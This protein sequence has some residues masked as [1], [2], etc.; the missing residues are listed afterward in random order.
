MVA[1]VYHI[2]GYA[3]LYHHFLESNYFFYFKY[4]LPMTPPC[5][6]VWLVGWLVGRL[7]VCRLFG[8]LVGWSVCLL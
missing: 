8:C 2:C 5:P 6:S 4:N 1:Y 7:L 3:D